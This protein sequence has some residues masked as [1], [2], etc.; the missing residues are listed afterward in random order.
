VRNASPSS[1]AASSNRKSPS[2]STDHNRYRAFI[3]K[4][5]SSIEQSQLLY[6]FKLYH[7]PVP[8]LQLYCPPASACTAARCCP[9]ASAVPAPPATQPGHAAASRPLGPLAA[10][11]R[12]STCSRQWGVETEAR[13]AS[14]SQNKQSDSSSQPSSGPLRSSST[15]KY[16]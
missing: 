11:A 6:A 5:F 1:H 8:V 13:V 10:A 12:Q 2:N 16:L 3:R 9:A 7:L 14:I 15:P 4:R